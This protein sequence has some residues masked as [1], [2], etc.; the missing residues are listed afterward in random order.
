M[1]DRIELKNLKAG[2]R[3]WE[4]GG[5]GNIECEALA[6]AEIIEETI[7]HLQT[8]ILVVRCRVKIL[9]SGEEMVFGERLGTGYGLNLYTAP[10]YLGVPTLGAPPEPV[11]E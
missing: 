3:F 5:Q 9:H 6:D 10:A 8:K 2:N 7:T 4:C 1:A 11:L